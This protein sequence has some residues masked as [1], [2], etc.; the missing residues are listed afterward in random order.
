MF[1]AAFRSGSVRP[2][3]DGA[4]RRA[5]LVHQ[6]GAARFGHPLDA[7]RSGGAVRLD[8]GGLNQ[9]QKE[10]GVV[11]E[12]LLSAET[13]AFLVDKGFWLGVA[14]ASWKC[15]AEYVSLLKERE[16]NDL[17]RHK[18]DHPQTETRTDS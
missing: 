12:K 2:Q 3:C 18:H 6:W 8:L 14:F 1:G 17:D 16:K 7:T 5:I 10:E 9:E 4:G 13:F 15:Y 11:M